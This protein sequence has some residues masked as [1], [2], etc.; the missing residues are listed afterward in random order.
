MIIISK[1]KFALE[2]ISKMSNKKIKIS[3]GVLCMRFNQITKKREYLLVKKSA[4]YNF[5]SFVLGKYNPDNP[6]KIKMLLDGTTVNEKLDIMYGTYDLLWM[7]AMRGI[8]DPN[9]SLYDVYLLGKARFHHVQQRED[10]KYIKR[11]VM[12]CSSVDYIWDFS[13]GR[14]TTVH[15]KDI[16]AALREFTEETGVDKND[17]VIFPDKVFR[18]KVVLRNVEYV[19][20][21]YLAYYNGHSYTPKINMLNQDQ[22]SEICDIRWMDLDTIASIDSLTRLYR[23]VKNISNQI[24]KRTNI[25]KQWRETKTAV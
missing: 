17:I 9:Q 16:D 20:Y 19:S 24:K 25:L 12:R 2:K 10:G 22:F 14:K 5:V 18:H 23:F 8:P 15:E 1:W 6:E 7:K 13:K 21:M 4:T 3:Y 11:I